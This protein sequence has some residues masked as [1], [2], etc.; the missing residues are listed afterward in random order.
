M[1]LSL[2]VL[3]LAGLATRP[4]PASIQLYSG[5][6]LAGWERI[7]GGHAFVADGKLILTHDD[8]MKPGYLVC[9][10]PPCRDFIVKAR[11]RVPVGDS[12]LFFRGE[13]HPLHAGEFQGPQVQLNLALGR[14]LGG[15]FEHHGRGWIKRPEEKLTAGRRADDWFYLELRAEG[16]RLIVKIDGQTM[17]DASDGGA[18]NHF[19]RAG[20]FALQ[21]HGGGP[22]RAEF[23]RI[24]LTPLPAP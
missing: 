11:C 24:E 6:D 14:G 16:P 17:V 8:K 19:L 23:E 7:G 12:G 20:R 10:R 21:I 1:H 9:T 3:L 22:V 4:E 5:N 15:L 2:L 18:D 13:R